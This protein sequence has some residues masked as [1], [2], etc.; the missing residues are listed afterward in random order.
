[1]CNQLKHSIEIRLVPSLRN[2]VTSKVNKWRDTNHLCKNIIQGF[3]SFFNRF[4]LPFNSEMN[5][6]YMLA[7]EIN[8]RIR[9]H[10]HK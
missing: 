2:Q 9:L 5:S 3:E 6:I 10:Q 4:S 8:L 1:M 7:R